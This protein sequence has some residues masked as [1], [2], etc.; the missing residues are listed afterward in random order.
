M[1][2]QSRA[3][4][5]VAAAAAGFFAYASHAVRRFEDVNPESTDAPGASLDVDGVRI[6]YVEA[7]QGEAV[8]LIHGI[9][10]STYS[11]RHAI[12][13]LAQHFRV[14]A[15]DLKGFG[16]SARPA[17]G[18]YSLTA[19]ADL[20]RQVMERLNIARATVLGHS[21][22]GAVAMRLAMR[23]PERVSRLVLVDSATDRE[24][25]AGATASKLL[26]PLMPLGALIFLHRRSLRR[27]L[28]STAVHDPAHLTPETFEAH[29]YPTRMK[30]H[31]RALGALLAQ[32]GR[33]KP[34]APERLQQPTLILWGEHDRWLPLSRGEELAGLIPNARLLSVPSAGHLPL[35]EQ[36]DFCNRALVAFLRSPEPAETPHQPDPT[37]TLETPA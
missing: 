37:T 22:G 24:M 15:L 5:I 1:S 33:D 27:L 9:G 28:L 10:A 3:L 21:M 4:P 35:E 19:H 34:L 25:G 20:V 32:R 17:E 31:L 11:F 16:Y 18:D 29:F 14:I 30:G 12:P 8:V 2:I 23:A 13:E 7:G 6:H 26:R 36:P